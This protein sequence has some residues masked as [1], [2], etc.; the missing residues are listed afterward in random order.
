MWVG[1]TAGLWRWKP[2]PPK[3][4]PMPDRRLVLMEGDDGALLIV[5]RGGIKRLVK[6]KL[7]AYPLPAPDRGSSP[8]GAPGSRWRS[9]DRNLGPRDRA[10]ASGKN[11]CV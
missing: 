4:Y 10:R 2:G 5:M 6:G 11:G 3:L 1:G 7:E 9:V 8:T